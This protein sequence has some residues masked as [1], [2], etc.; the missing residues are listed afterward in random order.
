MPIS[1]PDDQ[2][3]HDRM[4]AERRDELDSAID[5]A[6]QAFARMTPLQQSRTRRLHRESWVR[7]E[8]AMG[9]DAD[10]TRE[11]ESLRNERSTNEK[12]RQP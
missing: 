4:R 9:S 10:E 12:P 6:L 11:R 3:P 2:Y 1:R 5:R 7:G 8:M